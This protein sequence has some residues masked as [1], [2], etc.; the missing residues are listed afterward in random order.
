MKDIGERIK[1]ERIKAGM[2]QKQLA[3]AAGVAMVTV[4][5]YERGLREPRPTQLQAIAKALN[6]TIDMLMGLAPLLPRKH[7]QFAGTPLEKIIINNGE[8]IE[9]TAFETFLSEIGYDT[10]LDTNSFRSAEKGDTIPW[11]VWDKRSNKFYAVTAGNL[12]QL[13]GNIVAYT[14][15]QIYE[16]I[17]DATEISSENLPSHWEYYLKEKQKRER[18]S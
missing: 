14:K 10:I 4:S 1:E 2:T 13:Q 15:Y 17:H 16:L 18:D 7:V 3:E 8:N 11:I 9:F 5:Q 6:L 12:E